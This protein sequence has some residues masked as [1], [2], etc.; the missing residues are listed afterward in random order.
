VASTAPLNAGPMAEQ[1]KVWPCPWCKK[2][3]GYRSLTVTEEIKRVPVN[4]AHSAVSGVFNLVRRPDR[5]IRSL[6]TPTGEF[7]CHHCGKVVRVC[8][9][10]EKAVRWINSLAMVCTGCGTAFI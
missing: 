5:F 10:C 1:K 2:T 7:C 8:P 9:N 3:S 4:L 6:L